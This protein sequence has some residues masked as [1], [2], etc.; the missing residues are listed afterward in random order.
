MPVAEPLGRRGFVARIARAA[1][2]AA[3]A[4]AVL[5]GRAEALPAE[6]ADLEVLCASITL[7][8]HA[9]ALYQH[10]LKNGL[11]PAGLRRYAVEFLGDHEGHRDTEAGLVEERGGRV[12]APLH[13]Y[14]F[15]GITSSDALLRAAL[16][17]ELG[18]QKAYLGLISSIR[19]REYLLS[20]SFI[21]VDEVRH[22]TV[23]KR[24]LG[25]RIY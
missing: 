8:L 7:E 9:I 6:R 22:A 25:L 4:L 10:G 12:P 21:L 19:T 1:G 23:W 16:D 14:G 5:E 20:A 11:V 15:A 18:A 13:E 3:P 2:M 24:A 17:I